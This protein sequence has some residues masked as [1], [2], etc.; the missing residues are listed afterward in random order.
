MELKKLGSLGVFLGLAAMAAGCARAQCTASQSAAVQCF[1][2][3]AVATNLLSPRYG[4]TLAQFKTYGVA[5]SKILQD[6]PTYIVLLGMASAISDAMPPTNADGSPN[7]AAQQMSVN[8]IVDAELASN[9]VSI[10]PEAGEQDLQWFSLDMVSAMNNSTG[11]IVSPGALLRVVDS[12][13]VSA[14]TDG[15]VNWTK[16]N[17]NL[18]NMVGSLVRTGLLKLP[19]SVSVTQA[20]TFAQSL[21]QAINTY[22]AATGRARL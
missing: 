9:L 19:P 7:L 2:S 15:N 16:A 4:M 8:A 6:Q 17:N 18:A 21:A 5:V 12:Y 3:N 11:V 14:T 10:S 13:L 1:V 20:E 22:K